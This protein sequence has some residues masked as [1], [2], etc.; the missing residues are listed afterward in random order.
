[1]FV[2]NSPVI[3]IP[4]WGSLWSQWLLAAD[5]RLVHKGRWKNTSVPIELSLQPVHVNWGVRRK[6]KEP[7]PNQPGRMETLW[8]LESHLE[9]RRW[10]CRPP[11]MWGP[12][13]WPSRTCAA[14]PTGSG[15]AA[16]HSAVEGC[17]NSQS[18]VVS[19]SEVSYSA[20]LTPTQL[21]DM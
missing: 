18:T 5:G 4:W 17:E 1:M 11:G 16:A 14:P 8:G 3:V 20:L 12:L 21:K 9:T 15:S 7:S 2:L 13:G 6:Q 10:W 19:G